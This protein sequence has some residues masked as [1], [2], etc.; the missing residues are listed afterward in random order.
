MTD[1][2][3]QNACAYYLLFEVD[4]ADPTFDSVPPCLKVRSEEIK[5]ADFHVSL[6]GDR[7]FDEELCDQ[8]D[9]ILRFILFVVI[10]VLLVFQNKEPA[11]PDF[12]AFAGQGKT[13][14]QKRKN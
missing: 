1:A 9:S 6:S 12:E 13:L 10:F 2:A 14:R 4:V 11:K 8:T 3:A 7:Y 5:S